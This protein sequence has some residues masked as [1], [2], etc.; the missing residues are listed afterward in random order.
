MW[1]GVNTM[2]HL[3]YIWKLPGTNHIWA[4]WALGPVWM[5]AESLTALGFDPQTI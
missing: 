1:L 4:G 2:L 3:P 5:G